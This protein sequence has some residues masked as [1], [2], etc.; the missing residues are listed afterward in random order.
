MPE[1]VEVGTRLFLLGEAL[2]IAQDSVD[3]RVPLER[4]IVREALT[5]SVWVLA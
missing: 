5:L 1:Q 4:D 2:G 3:R